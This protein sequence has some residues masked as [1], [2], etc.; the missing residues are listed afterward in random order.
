MLDSRDN[1]SGEINLIIEM[2]E[3]SNKTIEKDAFNQEVA[4]VQDMKKEIRV[5]NDKIKSTCMKAGLDLTES[6]FI[7]NEKRI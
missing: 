1:L 3:Q 7:A 6:S 2:M 4:R 5:L